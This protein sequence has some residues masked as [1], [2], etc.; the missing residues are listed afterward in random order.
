MLEQSDM[1]HYLLSLGLVKPRDVVEEDL[2][3]SRRVA[4]ELR[5]PRHH[6]RGP[7]VRRQAGRAPERPHARARGRGPARARRRGGAGGRR[8]PWSSITSARQR[9]S[10]LSTPGGARDW[11]DHARSLPAHPGAGP[12]PRARD[13]ASAARRRGMEPPPDVDR[14]WA[15]SLPE[16]PHELLLGPER[17]SPGPRG[18]RA[19]QRHLCDRLDELRERTRRRRARARRPSL[20][21]LPGARG[22]RPR[23][24]RT[25]VLL[26]DWELA[27]AGAAAFDVGHRAG[28]VPER[29]GRIHPDRRPGRPGSAR[30]PRA[31][32]PAA[33]ASRDPRLLVGLSGRN[34]R[35]P[36]LRRV[37]ELAA[38]RLLQ[39]AVEH[40]QDLVVPIGTC[41]DPGAAR[42]QH[43]PR[44]RG[45]GAGA[46]GAA[47]VSR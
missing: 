34:P 21:Q 43:A 25:R 19:S 22:G 13:L 35:C 2:A 5:L 37:V 42:R 33:H 6:A 8:S 46:A 26:V 30:R 32:S 4:P 18:S 15:L 45:R 3:V 9:G 12:R 7:V 44:S 36:T 1:A 24:R 27:G 10:S 17:G 39:T 23:E 16:P 29:V 38:V 11:S 28:G 40:A 31:S 47:R 20:G 14:M 41:R